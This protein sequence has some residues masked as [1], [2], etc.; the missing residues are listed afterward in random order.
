MVV[1]MVSLVLIWFLCLFSCP[2][3]WEVLT[4]NFLY[5]IPALYCVHYLSPPCLLYRFLSAPVQGDVLLFLFMDAS[6]SRYYSY[7]FFALIWFSLLVHSHI[8]CLL[9]VF[10]PVFVLLEDTFLFIQTTVY[11]YYLTICVYTHEL[12]SLLVQELFILILTAFW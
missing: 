7:Y 4:F 5:I 11:H 10:T 3:F 2:C 12:L 6:V 8:M 1:D 9:V